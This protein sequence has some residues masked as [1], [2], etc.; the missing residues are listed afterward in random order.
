MPVNDMYMKR[1]CEIA[2]TKMGKTSPNP[3]V[4]A[5][6]VKNNVIIGEGGTG[7]FGGDHAEVSAIKDARKKGNDTEGASIYVSLEPCSH[8]GKTPPCTEAII[9]SGIKKVF[10]PMLDP[11]PMVAGN[12]IRQLTEAG[13]EIKIMHKHFHPASDLIRGFKKYILR[14]RPFIINKCAMTLDG[15]IAS[16]SGDSKWISNIY[17]RLFVHKLRAKV[18][19]IIIGKNTFMTDNPIL[20]V[21]F[22]EFNDDV[23][24]YL[25]ACSTKISGRENF[26]LEKLLKDDITDYKDPLRVMVGLPETV[27]VKSNFFRDNNYI[28]IAEEAKYNN[29]VKL[30]PELKSEYSRLNIATARFKSGDENIRFVMDVLKNAGIMTALL[31]GGGTLNGSFY[32]S[33]EI[34]Q[35]LYVIAPKVLGSGISPVQG[36]KSEKISDS[37][38]LRDIST[39]MVDDNILFN[40]YKEEYNFEMM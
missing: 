36:E 5:V 9:K 37:L 17:T 21:R 38:I 1:A 13:I 31:E 22:G 11:N 27:S 40:G 24:N 8:Y 7:K 16:S 6:I 34:D 35:F 14:N 26:F 33:G 4:G 23:S 25:A 15:K 3:A 30:H 32:N 2:F 12:G 28:I 20:N 10:T 19:A 29:T 18:D 39:V